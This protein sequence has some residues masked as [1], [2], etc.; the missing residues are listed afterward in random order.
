MRKITKKN[1]VCLLK[2]LIKIEEAAQIAAS[3]KIYFTMKTLV[4]FAIS[5][6]SF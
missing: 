1:G 4:N 2:I 3:S 6:I 5:F